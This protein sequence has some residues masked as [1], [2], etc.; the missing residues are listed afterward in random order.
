MLLLF[1]SGHL[2]F[3]AGG[4]AYGAEAES[5]S[6]KGERRVDKTEIISGL[7]SN[8]VNLLPQEKE[9]E[10]TSAE[11][12]SGTVKATLKLAG[13]KFEV[14]EVDEFGLP[15]LYTATA[16]YRGVESYAVAVA[17]GEA[18]AETEP[19]TELP[20]ITEPAVIL[21]KPALAEEPSVEYAKEKK[22]KSEKGI[23]GAT[24]AEF[25]S[26]NLVEADS[27]LNGT[28]G[29]AAGMAGKNIADSNVVHYIKMALLMIIAALAGAVITLVVL[30]SRYF[31]V[32]R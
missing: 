3:A 22:I 17:G 25:A 16:V 31:T 15:I 27:T 5:Q 19:V 30:K 20:A 12:K 23:N 9:F 8:D 4:P 14:S 32:N 29:P 26:L 24:D 28:G 21:A 10:I 13:A 7:S 2:L 11:A 18:E 6:D 1:G